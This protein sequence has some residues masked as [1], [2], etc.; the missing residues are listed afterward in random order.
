[1]EKMLQQQEKEEAEIV[2]AR[3]LEAKEIQK[4]ERQENAKHFKQIWEAQK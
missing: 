1:M 2:Q 3:H 4:I